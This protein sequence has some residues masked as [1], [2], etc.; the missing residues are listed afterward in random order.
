[1]KSNLRRAAAVALAVALSLPAFAAPSKQDRERSREKSAVVQVIK[2][3]QRLLGIS[4]NEDL[5]FPPP[6]RP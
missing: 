3:I 6:P 2:K 4:T 5:P 1:M